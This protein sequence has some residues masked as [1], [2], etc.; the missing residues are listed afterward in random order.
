MNVNLKC[1]LQLIGSMIQLE[2]SYKFT[3]VFTK[4]KDPC[5]DYF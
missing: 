4:F 3:E 2:S 5:L 1:L